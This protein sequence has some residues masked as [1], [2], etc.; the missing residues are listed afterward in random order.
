MKEYYFSKQSKNFYIKN[1][2]QNQK[3]K[4][5]FQPITSKNGWLY[6]KTSRN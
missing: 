5:H 4:T 6:K 1:S 2:G 3:N